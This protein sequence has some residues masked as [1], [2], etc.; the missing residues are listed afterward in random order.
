M[1]T[2]TDSKLNYL[3]LTIK[4]KQDQLLFYMYHKHTTTDPIIHDDI[5]YLVNR[6]N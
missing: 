4:N 1:E 3:D 5:N 6:M 2:E